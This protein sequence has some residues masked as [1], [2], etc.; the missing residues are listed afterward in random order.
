MLECG[1]QKSEIASSLLSES[2]LNEI[3][4]RNKD[5]LVS[6]EQEGTTF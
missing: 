2:N 6:V 1:P 3:S 5:G 4:R